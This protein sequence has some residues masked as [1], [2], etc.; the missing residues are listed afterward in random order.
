M[1]WKGKAGLQCY[2]IQ[3]R[4]FSYP[5]RH[6]LVIHSLPPCRSIEVRGEKYAVGDYVLLHGTKT[7][8]ICRLTGFVENMTDSQATVDIEWLYWPEEMAKQLRAIPPKKRPEMPEYAQHDVFLSNSKDSAG[9]ESIACKVSIVHLPPQQLSPPQSVRS[10]ENQYFARWHWDI[11]TKRFSPV[12]DVP[13]PRNSWFGAVIAATTAPISSPSPAREDHSTC[14]TDRAL[15]SRGSPLS[16]SRSIGNNLSRS[17]TTPSPLAHR[18][19][20]GK[21]TVHKSNQL[22]SLLTPKMNG[23]SLAST[24][25]SVSCKTTFTAETPEKC[26]TTPTH[27]TTHVFTPNTRIVNMVGMLG[28]LKSPIKEHPLPPIKTPTSAVR[29]GTGAGDKGES[30]VTPKRIISQLRA[31]DVVGLLSEGE[32]SEGLGSSSSEEEEEVPLTRQGRKSGCG[33]RRKED[34]CAPMSNRKQTNTGS[35][36]ENEI[37]TDKSTT[38]MVNTPRMS[39]RDRRG[40]K[41]RSRDEVRD[42]EKI[43]GKGSRDRVEMKNSTVKEEEEGGNKRK[44]VGEESE[45]ER[46]KRRELYNNGDISRDILTSS[47]PHVAAPD[48]LTTPTQKKWTLRTKSQV[49]PP[50]YLAADDCLV[51]NKPNKITTDESNQTRSEIKNRKRDRSPVSDVL[52]TQPQGKR[53]K[54]TPPLLVGNNTSLKEVASMS[55]RRRGGGSKDKLVQRTP[56]S[57]ACMVRPHTEPRKRLT[58]SA[59][60]TS[61]TSQCRG[62]SSDHIHG[63][64]W[65]K[66][67]VSKKTVSRPLRGRVQRKHIALH[68]D[69][70]EVSGE[71]GDSEYEL[72]SGNEGESSESDG[73]T[74]EDMEEEEYH[75]P[76]RKRRR[77][78]PPVTGTV[79]NWSPDSLNFKDHPRTPSHSRKPVRTPRQTKTPRTS[80]TPGRTPATGRTPRGKVAVTPH[81]PQRKATGR[82]GKTELDRARLRYSLQSLY[83][84]MYNVMYVLSAVCMCLLYPTA[85]HAERQS[86]LM[87]IHS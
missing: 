60:D 34:T 49:K 80:R 43:G 11:H 16:K 15:R 14:A 85:C 25:N 27:K 56:V 28:G 81:I 32:D 12:R 63:G 59:N 20:K 61:I 77:Q 58:A 2:E 29:R 1:D 53:V 37:I 41:G 8:L 57:E 67:K 30:K 86:L 22:L 18:G 17:P 19:G 7:K 23:M 70:H 87:S 4:L 68:E 66:D 46:K 26:N 48:I 47:T 55:H 9:I 73:D 83:V 62:P 33:N 54:Q 39:G 76:L 75:L 24:T 38:E 79:T 40:K 13:G 31:S 64:S 52:V 84:Y 6:Q 42:G 69:S 71:S 74:T 65:R 44:R 51:G 5:N 35:H 78:P 72:S 82:V 50:A 21:A 36:I 10:G 45:K 3:V